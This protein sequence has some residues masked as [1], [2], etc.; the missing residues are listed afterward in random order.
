MKQLFLGLLTTLSVILYSCGD[1]ASTTKKESPAE[2]AATEENAGVKVVKASFTNVDANAAGYI[3]KLAD[4][5]LQIKNALT[6]G[7]AAEAGDAAKN[8]GEAIK[9][10]DKS[11]LSSDQKKVYDVQEAGLKE[12]T[13]H[14]TNSA[15]DI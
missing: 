14:I 10:F 9:G 7:K 15:N 2:Q 4:N 12:N 11:L 13:E 6:A 8:M 3:K 5:Y 1:T